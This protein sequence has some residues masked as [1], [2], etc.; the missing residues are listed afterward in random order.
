MFTQSFYYERKSQIHKMAVDLTVIYA[1]L[2]SRCVK[3]ARK[4]WMKLTPGVN[5]IN[6]F[7]THFLY[8]FLVSSYFSAWHKKF[9]QKMHP[10]NVDE[11][12]CCKLQKCLEITSS[13][14]SDFF[15]L[16]CL[17]LESGNLLQQGLLFSDPSLL[18]NDVSK[19]TA[20]DLW[21]IFMTTFKKSWTIYVVLKY[22][23]FLQNGLAFLNCRHKIGWP[24][25]QSLSR[26][27]SNTELIFRHF[28][29]R[30]FDIFDI[31]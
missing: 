21:P 3:T 4:M 6:V 5:F 14:F 26:M 22:V 16:F 8:E 11:I 17:V 9:I 12:D 20:S 10:K 30:W 1:L 19:S 31:L 25:G 28:D 23:I 2:E 27:L 29:K 18:P 13:W 15:F 24:P 7:C